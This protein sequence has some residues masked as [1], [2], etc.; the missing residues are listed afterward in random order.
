MRGDFATWRLAKEDGQPDQVGRAHRANHDESF[1]ARLHVSFYTIPRKDSGHARPIEADIIADMAH[2]AGRLTP[3]IFALQFLTIAPPLIGRAPE[4]DELGA[5]EAWFPL[6]GLLLGGALAGIDLVLEAML[7]Q[8]VRDVILIAVLVAMT[9]ALHVDGLADAA[10]GVLGGSTPEARLSIMRDPRTGP[11][12]V[13]AVVL[14]LAL[15]IAALGAVPASLRTAALV[16]FPC[17]GRWAIVVATWWFPYA[18]PRGMGRSFKD[19][20]RLRHVVVAAMVTGGAC[21]W[22]L[23]LLGLGWFAVATAIVWLVGRT[24]QGRV[25]GLTGDVYGGLCELTQ[26]GTLVLLGARQIELLR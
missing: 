12:G 24:V 1:K 25:G 22:Q 13:A 9:G 20:I 14:V 6:I 11:F 5:S 21:A 19:G 10:D 8:A 26:A 2:P 4:D 18:R 16:T 7:A 23:G 3:P 15:Q 17:L